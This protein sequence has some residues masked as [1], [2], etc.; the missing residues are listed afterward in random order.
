[1]KRNQ[2][3]S[4]LLPIV[5]FSV[6]GFAAMGYHPGA[7]DDGVYLSAIKSDL[8]PALFP[9]DSDFFRLQLQAT[10]FDGWMANFVQ[11]TGISVAWTEIIWQWVAILVILW[12]CRE[13]AGQI[14]P[15]RHAQWAAV[16]LVSAMFTLPV[17][18]TA[19]TLVDQ[20]LHP[21]AL[22]T[23]LI[24]V[25][26]S[27]ILAGKRW[28]A[29]PCVILAIL[30]HPIMGVLGLSFCFFLTLAT[31]ETAP[32]WLRL[33]TVTT[34]AASVSPLGWIFEPPS[35]EWRQALHTRTYFFLTKWT[36]YEWLGALVPLFLFCLL[37][38]F[39][40]RRGEVKLARL[41]L[42]IFV[43]GV[44]QQIVA[45]IV[46]GVPAFERLRPMQPMRFLHLIY[47]FLCLIG[48]GLLGKF[49]LKTKVWRWAVFLV[50]ANGGMFYAQRQ[51]FAGTPHMEFPGSATDNPWLQ[52]FAWIR[53]NTP[54]DAYFALDPNY[55]AAPGE[56]YHSFRALAERSELSDA[57]KDAAVATQVPSLAPIWRDQ[58][59]AMDGWPHFQLHDFERL[60]S[61]YKVNWVI[62][63]Y[64]PAA[65][66]T[67]AWHNGSVSVCKIP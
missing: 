19:L 43:Y 6:L 27:R 10:V 35:P 29:A 23:A 7:E 30:L 53:K 3:L 11:L 49:L 12:A 54:E 22:A 39:A 64:P 57:I 52:A 24:L 47:V 61:R 5:C 67:C 45:I 37:W 56:D 50:V 51:L 55:M 25:G 33:R 48:G 14:F 63:S 59:V 40:S 18:G 46:L 31:L 38:R 9:H 36:W 65:G 42:A 21:R 1:L 15:E 26:V 66:L 41:A 20:H 2:F 62:V 17:A 58:Q 28:Q 60:K 8:H 13:I 4:N 44:F 16:A 32:E 34:T